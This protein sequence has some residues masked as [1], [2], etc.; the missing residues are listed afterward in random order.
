M[1]YLAIEVSSV[2]VSAIGSQQIRPSYRNLLT[3]FALLEDATIGCPHDD[4]RGVCQVFDHVPGTHYRTHYRTHFD[5]PNDYSWHH[6]LIF[7]ELA[8]FVLNAFIAGN[9]RHTQDESL[10]MPR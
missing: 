7:V 6:S 8:E 5:P 10:K 1:K 4:G 3:L 2:T 9:A